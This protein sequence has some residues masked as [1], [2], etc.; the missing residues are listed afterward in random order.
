MVSQC[1]E[2]RKIRKQ[3]SYPPL[4]A[5]SSLDQLVEQC[6]TFCLMLNFEHYGAENLYVIAALC[7]Q[8]RI[9]VM[10]HMQFCSMHW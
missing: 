4:A 10:Q 3:T 7:H 5:I 8:V 1:S 9:M 6:A 2:S